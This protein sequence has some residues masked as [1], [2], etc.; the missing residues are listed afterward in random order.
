[1]YSSTVFAA[2]PNPSLQKPG[3]MLNTASKAKPLSKALTQLFVPH[4]I[5]KFLQLQDNTFSSPVTPSHSTTTGLRTSLVLC[6]RK[7]SDCERWKNTFYIF[8]NL[9]NIIMIHQMALICKPMLF[10]AFSW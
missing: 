9:F 5:A 7:L 6:Q 8:P 2:L 4:S 10:L 3:D 1:M